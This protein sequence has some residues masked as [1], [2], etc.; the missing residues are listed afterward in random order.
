MKIPFEQIELGAVIGAGTVGAVYRGKLKNSGEAVAVKLLQPAISKDQLVRARFARE[1]DI[2]DKLKHPNI[3]RYYGGGSH[4]GRL[5]YAMEPVETGTVKELLERFGNLS[6]PEVASIARQVASA[7]QH[8]HNHGII[9]RDLKPGN[10]FITGSGQIK[11]GD[12]GIARDTHSADL[13]NEGLTVGTHAYMAPEQITGE[14]NITGK[15]DLY[16]LGCLMFELLTGQKPF[17]GTNFAVLFE[18]HLRKPAPRVS[19]FLPDCPPVLVDMVAQ[20][21]EKDPER[22]P[23][24]AR[25]VQG[26][27]LQLLEQYSKRTVTG[28]G[29]LAIASDEVSR[30]GGP[31]ADVGAASVVD[32][33]MASLVRKLGPLDERNVSWRALTFV[34]AIA[35]III[36]IAAFASR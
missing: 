29:K 1:M 6:W 27:M 7:L 35:V 15:A 18:Q 19:D 13:T 16:S 24:N 25:A 36:A 26:V 14:A 34:L 10:L 20:L 33:G 31:H 32:P 8:A 17:Q 21:L 23:F 2:L 9:H 12:F 22:R 3:I 4:D 5:F 28:Q 30:S 11:L